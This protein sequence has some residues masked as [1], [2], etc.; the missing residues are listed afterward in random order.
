MSIPDTCD[1]C[2][3]VLTADNFGQMTA[4]CQMCLPCCKKYQPADE[5]EQDND[6]TPLEVVVPIQPEL[7][8]ES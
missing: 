3:D 4:D 5:D 2:G 1:V 7:G 8:G 6:P